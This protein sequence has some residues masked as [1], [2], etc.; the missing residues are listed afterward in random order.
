MASDEFIGGIDVRPKFSCVGCIKWFD[1]LNLFDCIIGGEVNTL[2]PL[3]NI[4]LLWIIP[5]S[6]GS[7]N[8]GY[9]LIIWV[10]LTIRLES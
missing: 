3:L 2:F 9:W 4:P 10:G 7:V 6:L 8:K 1:R 5:D